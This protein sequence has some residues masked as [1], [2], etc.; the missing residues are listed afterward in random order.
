VIG[1][2]Y[3]LIYVAPFQRTVIAVEDTSINMRYVLQ[4]AHMAGGAPLATLE[5]LTQ[6][7]IIKQVAPQP[8]YNIEITAEDIDEALRGIARG[9]GGTISDSEFREWYRQQLNENKLSDAE[10]RDLIYTMLLKFRIRQHLAEGV[11]AKA[12]QVY[13]HAIFVDSRGDAEDVRT[14]WE[15]GEAFADLAREVSTDGR[16]ENGGEIGWLPYEVLDAGD[17]TLSEAVRSLDVGQVSQ[18][19]P[20]VQAE[21]GAVT[22]AL[23]MV[24]EKAARDVDEDALVVL[25]DE[26]FEDW[27]LDVTQLFSVAWYGLNN[28]FDSETLA[29]IDWQL[30]KMAR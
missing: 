19:V 14:R 5:L 4:R 18:P 10:Y 20:I 28:G 24:S 30:Q 27:I 6:E 15:A 25:Q 26:A 9:E 11:P 29:W 1:V 13:L 2:G 7:L 23:M 17:A 22:Y 3:Y 16:A 8:P 21:S 12:M